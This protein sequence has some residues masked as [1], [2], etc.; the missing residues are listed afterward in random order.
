M[1]IKLAPYQVGVLLKIL[2]DTQDDIFIL[3]I[4]TKRKYN[5]KD[6]TE[7][8][9]GLAMIYAQQEEYF[10]IICKNYNDEQKILNILY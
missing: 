5:L 3:S 9:V 7:R 2:N 8:K 6:P 10:E 4:K 1:K